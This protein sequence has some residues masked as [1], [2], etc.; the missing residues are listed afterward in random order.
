[1]DTRRLL[2]LAIFAWFTLWSVPSGASDYEAGLAAYE[3][4]RFQEALDSWRPV[5]EAGDPEAQFG[6]G[7]LYY[8]GRGVAKDVEA[9]RSWYRRAGALGHGRALY[10]LGFIAYAGKGAEGRD[11]DAAADWWHKGAAAGY[12]LAMVA[13]GNAYENG[14]GVPR[15]L[16]EAF[17]WNTLGVRHNGGRPPMAAQQNLDRLAGQLTAAQIQEA[18]GRAASWIP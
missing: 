16:V 1:M 18:R 5:A 9:A 12:P 6:L 14:I 7:E 13:L 17:M 3:Q 2:I 10:S 4:G 11:V 8:W 15:D